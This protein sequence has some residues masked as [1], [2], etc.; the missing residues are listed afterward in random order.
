MDVDYICSVIS[1]LEKLFMVPGYVLKDADDVEYQFTLDQHWSTSGRDCRFVGKTFDLHAAYKQFT[2]ADNDLWANCIITYNPTN[3][4]PAYFLQVTLP[5]G[6]TSAVLSFNR[7]SRALWRLIILELRIIIL[8]YF[9]DYPVIAPSSLSNVINS[10]VKVFCKMLGWQLS[11]DPKKDVEFSEL[12]TAL[13]VQFEI[14][15][16]TTASCRVMNTVK[17]TES[18][19]QMI[20]S[21]LS[22][23]TMS[24]HDA[25]VLRG[26]LQ[27][28]EAQIFG[29][30]GKSLFKHFSKSHRAAS[31]WSD[32]IELALIRIRSWLVKSKP[33]LVSAIANTPTILVFTDGACEPEGDDLKLSCGAILFDHYMMQPTVQHFGCVVN[34]FLKREWLLSGRRQLVTECELLPVLLAKKYWAPVLRGRKVLW[35]VDSEPSKFSL[36]KGSSDT[37]ECN[38]IVSAIHL[39]DADAPS[40]DWYARVPSKS[41]PADAPSRLDFDEATSIFG[42]TLVEVSQPTSLLEGCWRS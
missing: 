34:E 41:N 42:S 12:F 28:M 9:D 35:Y 26:R 19:I 5:F 30:V 20:D 7:A 29:R 10:A 40:F 6:A 8:N 24:K 13:G 1:S 14:S 16:I 18:V 23:K 31:F 11:D 15:G 39:L 22:V 36:I 32:D 17:R 21:Y 27:F 3:D 33:R 38:R 4:A 37:E 25:E 2:V